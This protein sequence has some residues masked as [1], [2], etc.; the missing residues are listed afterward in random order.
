MSKPFHVLVISNS[1]RVT[2]SLKKYLAE[3]WS[4]PLTRRVNTISALNNA[5]YAEAW[6]C[7]ICDMA[8][9]GFQA[10]KALT[11]LKHSEVYLPF[12]LISK[13]EDL[14]DAIQLLSKGAH[15]FARMSD[16]AHIAPVV[17][18]AIKQVVHSKQR[19]LAE[20]RLRESEERY[21]YLFEHSEVS[22]WHDD[23]SR[24]YT[25]LEQLRKEGLTDLRSYLEADNHS[26][27][28]ALANMI[29][30][31]SVNSASMRLFG[32]KT[33]KELLDNT[34]KIFG[35]GWAAVFIDGFCAYWDKQHVFRTSVSFKTTA[36]K[37]IHALISIPLPKNKNESRSVPVNITDISQQVLT[38]KALLQ[39]KHIVSD[40]RDMLALLDQDCTFIAVNE[41]FVT[42]TGWS[43][44]QFI[45][46]S[47][48][49]IYG[50]KIFNTALKPHVDSCLKGH[51]V[52]TQMW[53]DFPVGGRIFLDVQFTPH[54]GPDD[55]ITSFVVA[56]R[57]S[58]RFEINRSALEY[59]ST[60]LSILSGS[61]FFVALA[62]H[63][64]S[65]LDMAYV[66][67][68][69]IDASL[70]EVT[71]LAGIANGQMVALP[72]QYTLPGT[73]CEKVVDRA[74]CSWDSGVQEQFPNDDLLTE[75]GVESYM[76]TAL[77]DSSG[78]VTGLITA[79]D[80]QP[81]ED[82]ATKSDLFRLFAS[83]AASE[84]ERIR[85]RQVLAA[86][87]K[88]FKTL[89]EAS[90]VGIYFDDATGR[91]R[92]V[93]PKYLEIT[94][95]TRDQ[96]EGSGWRQCIHP[97][98]EE[99]VF[100]Q[101][102][103]A[104]QGGTEFSYEYRWCH[105]DGSVCWTADTMLP[106]EEPEGGISGFIGTVID[107]TERK[108]HEEAEKN[109]RIQLKTLVNILPDFI[110]MKNT[111]GRYL[112]CNH[113]M[114]QYFGVPEAD[115]I[116]KTDHD[117]VPG[118]QADLYRTQ[119]Q[120]ML[121]D[122]KI[123]RYEK[124]ITFKHDGHT[125]I[126]EV[127]KLPILAEDGSALGIVGIGHDVTSYKLQQA[128]ISLD[129]RR[130]AALLK[131]QNLSIETGQLKCL[132]RGIEIAEELTDSQISYVHFVH[133]DQEH[134]RMGTWS[135]A[136]LESCCQTEGETHYPVSEAGI[137]ADALRYG[138]AVVF[139]DY[140]TC[141]DKRGLP[142]GHAELKRLISLPVVSDGKVVLV[143]GVGN[144]AT[145]YSDTDIESFQLIANEVW[146]IAE[147][148]RLTTQVRKLAL[149]VEQSPESIVITNL[150]AEIEYVNQT[151]VD[152]TGYSAREVLG[153]NPRILQSGQTPAETYVTMWEKLSAGSTWR[154]EFCNRKKD[155][156]HYIEKSIITPLK[157]TDGETIGYVAIKQDITE[158][159]RIAEELTEHRYHLER[160]VAERTR[161]LSTAQSAAQT[162]ENQFKNAAEI[163]HLGHWK[164]DDVKGGYA[165]VSEEYARICGLSVDDFMRT[166]KSMTDLRLVHPQDITKF[167]TCYIEAGEANLDFR[168]IRPDGEL[169]YVHGYF[170]S[171]NDASGTRISTEGSLQDVTARKLSEIKLQ[172]AIAAAE[173]ANQAKSVF[174]ANMSHEIRTPMNAILGIT[175][176]L[177]NAEPST[178]QSTQLGK[179]SNSAKHLLSVI[180][181]IL[182]ISKIEAGKLMLEET[183]FHLDMVFDHI[184]S[185][186]TQQAAE[187]DLRIVS[188]HEQASRWF[189]GDVTRLRQSLINYVGNAIKFS[190]HGTISL[191][192]IELEQTDEKT[193]IRFEV[194][195]AGI[196]IDPEKLSGLF[197]DFEQADSS[198]T[199]EYGGTGLGLAITRRLAHLMGG[200]AGAES[201]PGE[202]STF[203]FTAWLARGNQPIESGGQMPDTQYRLGPEHAGAHILLAEDNAI[204]REVA[205]AL[206]TSQG[207]K[208]DTAVNGKEAVAMVANSAYDLILM[209]VQMPECDGL[210]ATRLI[211]CQTKNADIPILAMTANVFVEDRNACVDA[212]MNDF[213]A[214][215]VEPDGLFNLLAKWLPNK[216]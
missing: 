62:Q 85:G 141:P 186:Y 67:V 41:A 214:K 166:K 75:W 18:L 132:Q 99:Q 63:L 74:F 199:R 202:G 98:D 190:A 86:S 163:A 178:E 131:L 97:D 200:D 48:A 95:L 204:N 44:D 195:D 113:K 124:E 8:I 81:M 69:K 73:P 182:D 94:G 117:F 70:A 153:E 89:T 39:Y 13:D 198:T 168:I 207:L 15:G 201:T 43:K 90:P 27:V 114:G 210:E 150:D 9:T 209:D 152:K 109:V 53:F 93:N 107:I 31:R 33:A 147:H 7:V 193:L 111:K 45:G 140:A 167:K 205:V 21:R 206:L 103:R 138:K 51:H 71:V 187:K 80:T 169:R 161:E 136:T 194:T 215:P 24:A 181:D 54:Y 22:I 104:I 197:R 14:T 142:E 106:V 28:F 88:K 196:G 96:A 59:L 82:V 145:D 19:A 92:Y 84:I 208:V 6:D 192:A 105:A 68:D 79:M 29:E 40:T 23:F 171:N 170:K 135:S 160:L 55:T 10:A 184:R 49:E 37:P 203:W 175:H 25:A 60:D 78:R 157:Q 155:G 17:K 100:T 57:D 20:S 35:H 134:L 87:E 144:K 50:R 34:D 120:A 26:A 72:M 11:L 66:F 116:G 47:A 129:A 30:V 180:N 130:T 139:N 5:L 65:A 211:R 165:S 119:D 188:N 12:I 159:K 110:W 216:K 56:A 146:R 123:R 36:G 179:I 133:A 158:Q 38:E 213:V 125:E 102:N 173:A 191:R 137:W 77:S 189:K 172:E 154:G 128:R 61:E 156:S 122:A 149:V 83:R 91:R 118:N 121:A 46:H 1:K 4:A 151:F 127:T 185:L 164:F 64:A 177:Q 162:S 108:E 112:A 58:T 126:V 52:S 76:G 42:P 115:I 174:L 16:L 143:A 176:L 183:N 148:R 212:G 3:E 32:V 2:G 101:W